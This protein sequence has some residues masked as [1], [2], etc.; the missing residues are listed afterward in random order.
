MQQKNPMTFI[1]LM[2]GQD[3]DRYALFCPTKSS[4]FLGQRIKLGSPEND[5]EKCSCVFFVDD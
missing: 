2:A 4:A 1:Y 5:G 3:V